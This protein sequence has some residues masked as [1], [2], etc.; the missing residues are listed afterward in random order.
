MKNLK[1]TALL[2]AF[3]CAIILFTGCK[4]EE[5]TDI[6]FSNY[7]FKTSDL[8]VSFSAATAT[9]SQEGS[10]TYAWDFG[11]GTSSTEKNP[12]HTYPYAGT[13]TATLNVTN[14]DNVAKYTY[15][16]T[17]PTG[18]FSPISIQGI[19]DFMTSIAV[20]GTELF[21]GTLPISVSPL[22]GG[23]VYIK[24]E[25]QETWT[26]IRSGLP[27]RIAV[28]SL[29]E[30]DGNIFAGTDDGVYLF[31][32]T[33]STWAQAGFSGNQVVSIVKSGSNL[34]AG[35]TSGLYTSSDNATSWTLKS[36]APIYSLTENGSKIVAGST[37]T[38][39]TSDNE[40]STWTTNSNVTANASSAMWATGRIDN[41]IFAALGSI[42]QGF[43]GSREILIS[44]DNGISFSDYDTLF[45]PPTDLSRQLVTSFV[46]MGSRI[47]ANTANGIFLSTNS[48]NTRWA[49]IGL[50]GNFIYSS[51]IKNNTIYA[52]TGEEIH[53]GTF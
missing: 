18:T 40:G 34:I 49:P 4:K 43:P 47:F 30:K 9:S 21:V 20:K 23:G 53:F 15:V 10:F 37:N 24:N 48:G 12:V 8:T 46:T 6:P 14:G 38:I 26:S 1:S 52:V 31:N 44:K 39:L 19:S 25:G 11:D 2:T 36:G 32:A 3:A 50:Q 22:T 35:T 28:Y 5:V 16:V 51:L 17:V 27:A 7:T 42:S 29:L 45:P 41:I 13:Y 33:D